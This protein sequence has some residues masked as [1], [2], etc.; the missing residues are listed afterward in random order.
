MRNGGG[1]PLQKEIGPL[2]NTQLCHV[3]DHKGMKVKLLL[4]QLLGFEIEKVKKHDWR[5]KLEIF[6]TLRKGTLE[7]K[8]FVKIL[9]YAYYI[10]TYVTF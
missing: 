1:K 5:L 9:P 2:V 6:G 4:A 8:Y 10:Y 3:S 7:K